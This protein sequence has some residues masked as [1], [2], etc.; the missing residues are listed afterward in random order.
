ML[1]VNISPYSKGYTYIAW[2]FVNFSG[3]F[4]CS[5]YK[6]R[7]VSLAG[8][9]SHV[10]ISYKRGGKYEP[11]ILQYYHIQCPSKRHAKFLVR[12]SSI[13]LEARHSL[14]DQKIC[15][16]YVRIEMRSTHQSCEICGNEKLADK[17]KHIVDRTYPDS[18]S[19]MLITFRTD[20]TVEGEGYKIFIAC[21]SNSA[22]EEEEGCLKTSSYLSWKEYKAL[23]R[24]HEVSKLQHPCSLKANSH[25][26]RRAAHYN[27]S[28]YKL[29]GAIN[30][31]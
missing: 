28:A 16:D 15:L 27:R 4:E 25:C 6:K 3:Q 31:M 23:K 24:S 26:T 1:L 9:N 29:N 22:I 10:L 19:D 8:G 12:S 30:V 18:I 21:N 5:A 14:G 17:C 13:N 2:P 7:E 11:Y 20:P